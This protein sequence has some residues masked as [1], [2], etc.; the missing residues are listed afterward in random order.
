MVF[1]IT[2][3]DTPAPFYSTDKKD[4]VLSYGEDHEGN[5]IGLDVSYETYKHFYDLCEDG[6]LEYSYDVFLLNDGTMNICVSLGEDG[7]IEVSVDFDYD[8][9]DEHA[10]F[11]ESE[12]TLVL[13]DEEK[14]II[15]DVMIK[16][17]ENS[18]RTLEDDFT[19]GTKQLEER[20]KDVD[21]ER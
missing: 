1:E 11:S 4:V 13:T 20:F 18:G 10:F 3:V 5:V 7:Y 9:G 6:D 16:A 14:A 19:N 12:G 15:K 21:V 17:I 2:K 8:W